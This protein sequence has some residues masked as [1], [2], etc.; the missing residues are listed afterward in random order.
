[1]KIRYLFAGLFV[2]LELPVLLPLAAAALVTGAAYGIA[3]LCSQARRIH[4]PL[5]R[6]LRRARDERV[7]RPALGS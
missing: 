6:S 3:A 1:M 2:I 5:R 4:L 7:A